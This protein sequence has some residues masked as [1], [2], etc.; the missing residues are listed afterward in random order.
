MTC[1][2]LAP[3]DFTCLQMLVDRNRRY[4]EHDQH[5]GDSRRNGPVLVGKEFRPQGLADHGG[6][7]TAQQIRNDELTDDGHEAQKSPRAEAP[8]AERQRDDEEG[9]PAWAT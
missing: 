9:L 8:H 7:G 1:A 6:I 4:Q 2:S 3:L 5:Y